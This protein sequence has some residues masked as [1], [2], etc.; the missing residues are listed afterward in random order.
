MNRFAT[1]ASVLALSA[2]ATASPL[3][4]FDLDDRSEDEEGTGRIWGATTTA[5]SFNST[6]LELLAAAALTGLLISILYAI[7]IGVNKFDTSGSGSGYGY[8]QQSYGQQGYGQSSFHARSDKKL[9]EQELAGQ[10]LAL[11]EAYKKYEVEDLNCQIYVACEAS[12]TNKH[13][14][15]GILAKTVYGIMKAMNKHGK[16]AVQAQDEYVASLIDAFNYGEQELIAGRE[17]T[18]SQLR[19]TCYATKK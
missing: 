10:M 17:D 19:E 1:L 11:A 2:F 8:S 9:V 7:T 5:L 16:K 18:C 14:E 6:S 13:E 12:Q 4:A 15:N 3:G